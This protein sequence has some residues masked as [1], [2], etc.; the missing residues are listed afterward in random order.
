MFRVCA[1]VYEN[2]LKKPNQHKVGQLV[3]MV[4]KE[5]TKLRVAKR[6][7]AKSSSTRS[8]VELWQ[9]SVPLKQ[10]QVAHGL[11]FSCKEKKEISMGAERDAV[12]ASRAGKVESGIG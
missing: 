8:T 4:L 6:W 12:S 2:L 9:Q 5:A 1:S 7:G 10:V 3:A 11:T